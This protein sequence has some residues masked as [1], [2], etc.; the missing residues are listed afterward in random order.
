[1]TSNNG[2]PAIRFAGF[3]DAWEQRKLSTYLVTSNEK[4]TEERFTRDD[5]LSVSGDFGIVNQI[6]FQGRSFAGASV[7]NY[8]V[9]EKGDV[10]YTKSPLSSNPYGI[11]KTNKG[12][13][14]IVSTL[15]AVYHPHNNVSSD[16][17]QTY[18]E[19]NA[20]VN[21]YLQPLVNKGAKNDMKVSADNALKGIV[22]F[23]D[24]EEQN[25]ISRFFT[26]LDDLITLHQRKYDQLVNIKKSMLEKMFPKN[27]EL[28]P[29]VRF[30]GFTDLPAGRQALGK[31]CVYVLE[32]D[33]G[34]LY[35]GKTNDLIRRISEHMKG[36]G[37]EHT[38]KHKPVKLVYFEAFKSEEE[39]L[40]KEQYLKSGSGR[41]WLKAHL[42]K[43]LPLDYSRELEYDHYAW[44]QRRLGEY[45]ET[46]TE[47]NTE[48]IYGITDVL[49]VSGDSGV[50]NQIEFQ[51]RSFAGASV[52][53]YGILRTGEVVY[54]KSPL[55]SAPYGIIKT[56]KGK[57]GIV[58]VLYGVY[59]PKENLKSELVQ[60]YFEQNA[61]L[62]NYLRPLVNKGAKN[63]LLISDDDALRGEVIFPKAISEQ[64]KICAL[65]SNLDRLI[66]LHQRKLEKLKN[67][68][69][70]ML[71][72]MFV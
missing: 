47:K 65:F 4:N 23:P 21:N 32:C 16:F 70:A 46:S 58:S 61:R 19:Q 27:G 33:D 44:E 42:Q 64:R 68:K 30:A 37:A 17:V 6:E 59:R 66:T 62:N 50:V 45:L 9:V 13:A 60:I 71:E 39:A 38:Q 56:N 20:R 69:K 1:M 3:T 55:K 18:F 8:G 63:T 40:E 22:C 5:V 51:G 7:V 10:V 41:E 28:V 67:I 26:K 36:H 15:Y 72:R 14:G 12:K 49:S 29:E 43:Y 25:R 54:T 57:T 31:W 53:G 34:S 35:K 11:I 48:N 24:Y 2:T 52:S